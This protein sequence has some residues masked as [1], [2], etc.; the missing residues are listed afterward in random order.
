M[1][2]FD[3]NMED[4]VGCGVWDHYF[5]RIKSIAFT[6]TFQFLYKNPNV[7]EPF[8]RQLVGIWIV[9][10]TY[11]SRGITCMQFVVNTTPSRIEH[12]EKLLTTIDWIEHNFQKG[13]T[14]VKTQTKIYI[15]IHSK[16]L[17]DV[18]FPSFDVHRL[19]GTSPCEILIS[20]TPRDKYK[21]P[22]KMTISSGKSPSMVT[23][24][25]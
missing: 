23:S 8:L 14:I 21:F 13:E 16:V 25:C 15:N 19:F 5:K 4:H 24:L 3:T 17:I 18:N 22:H 11:G 20:T 1:N 7:M 6:N 12:S 9:A 2:T 10:F